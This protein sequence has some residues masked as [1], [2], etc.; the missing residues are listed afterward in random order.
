MDKKDIYL[1][2]KSIKGISS[3][4]LGK[5]IDEVGSIEEIVKLNE[6]D[7]YNLKNISLNIKENLV[8]YISRFN[9]DEIKETLY[10]E[11]IQYICIEDEE[12]RFPLDRAPYTHQTNSWK[13]LLND[14]KTIVVTSGTG[15]GK[16]ECFMIPVIQDLYRQKSTVVNEGVQAIF[17]C[18][19]EKPA[20][21]STCLVFCTF[22]KGHLCHIQW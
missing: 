13:T 15:S 12:Y 22:T 2:I 21:K 18:P 14:K 20:K 3:I 8:K 5:I 1:Y 11:S 6:K 16:T 7:I 10:K 19:D 17:I 9:L 4:T